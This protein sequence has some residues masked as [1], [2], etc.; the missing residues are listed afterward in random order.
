MSPA[1]LTGVVVEQSWEDE[2]FFTFTNTAVLK[3]FTAE[4][5]KDIA[6]R[7]NIYK[8]TFFKTIDALIDSKFITKEDKALM[9]G[10][11]TFQYVANCNEFDGKISLKQWYNGNKVRVRNE[12]IGFNINVNICFEPWFASDVQTSVSQI[13][14]HELWHYFY[15]FHD[16]SPKQFEAICRVPWI[17][18]PICTKKNFVSEYAMSSPE[19]DYAE[20]FAFR[21]LKKL[22]PSNDPQLIQKKNYFDAIAASLQ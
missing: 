12:L 5:K 3:S 16:Q 19:E 18:K 17:N 8:N 9:K 11:V 14:A 15:Y 22:Y 1:A 2:T 7:V 21:F 10:K 20:S 4:Q 13:M 6:A